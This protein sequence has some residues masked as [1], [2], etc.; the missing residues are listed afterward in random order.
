[1]K[2]GFKHVWWILALVAVIFCAVVAARLFHPPPGGPE[3]VNQTRAKLRALGFKTD[4]AEFDLSTPADMRV[5]E[6]ILMAAIPNPSY[7][8]IQAPELMEFDNDSAIV[9]WKQSGLNMPGGARVSWDE[10][11]GYLD[12]NKD[13]IDAA[14]DAILSGPIGF[15]LNAADGNEIRLTHLQMLHNLTGTLGWR[16]MIA[17]HDGDRNTAW[18]NL[19]AA[20][21]LVTA[22][23]I[24][25]GEY[26]YLVRSS[27][28]NVVFDLTWQLLQAHGWDDA[29]LKQL[30][31][32]W[33]S[34]NALANLP[35]LAAFKRAASLVQFQTLQREMITGLRLP[36][37]GEMAREA[38]QHPSF[39][40]VA[41]R[42]RW[43]QNEFLHGAIY[44][45]EA[46]MLNYYCDLEAAWR[47]ATNA[48]NWLRISA[49]PGMTNDIDYELQ[50]GV[51]PG[52]Q[53]RAMSRLY[54]S[55][56]ETTF[57]ARLAE[58]QA[59][60]GIL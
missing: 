1:M 12:S 10:V 13:G 43:R 40:W 54:R 44:Q 31:D 59:R 28:E 27:E 33:E 11:R 5:R 19:L 41:M 48:S 15:N 17:L 16:T 60:R 55:P 42:V 3:L 24:E 30:Q 14:C 18:T 32:E 25:P 34:F 37:V 22:W 52:M 26:S 35:E 53:S 23:K 46:D 45:D 9:V 58:A 47:K 49:V 51:L 29:Q 36:P 21:R 2:I 8:F 56:I 50:R 6:G 20:T 39:L 4:L 7:G 57:V 38:L